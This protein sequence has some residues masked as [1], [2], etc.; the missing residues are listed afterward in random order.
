MTIE[1]I[2]FAVAGSIVLL[3]VALSHYVNVNW[4]WLTAWLTTVPVLL[5]AHRRPEPRLR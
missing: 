3:S 4:L 5:P 1:R 2:V